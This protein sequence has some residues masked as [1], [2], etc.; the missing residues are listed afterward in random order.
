MKQVFPFFT[1]FLFFTPG[2]VAQDTIAPG[3]A[4]YV[5]TLEDVI[6]LSKEQS[7]QAIMARH[8]FRASY[9]SFRTYK[10][11]F[12]PK[13]VLTT[14]PASYTHSIQTISS[15]DS[16]GNYQTHETNVNTFTS[17]AGLSLSQN[18][19]LT[20]GS[21]ALGSNIRRVQNLNATASNTQY[22]TFPVTLSLS[23]P[24]N[25]YNTLKWDKKIEPVRFEQAKQTY[26]AQM[27]LISSRA[28]DYFFGLARQQVVLKMAETNYEN[29]KKLYEIS[30]GRYNI[31][32]IAEDALLKMELNCMT[33]ESDLYQAQIDLEDQQSRLRSFLG[34]RDN[35]EIELIISS[36]LPKFKIKFQQ[37]LDYALTRSP[38]IIRYNLELLT[39]ERN[40]AQAKSQKGVTLSVEGSYGLNKTADQFKN[41]Y[42]TPFID[43]EGISIGINIPILDW[44]Q[45]NDRYRNF[46]SL[47]EVAETQKAQ[48]EIDFQQNV[49]LQVARFNLQENQ[50]SIAAK[51]D[52]IA[53]KAYD[54]SMERYLI[55]KVS[56]TDLNI[57]SSDKDASKTRYISQLQNYW[58]YFYEVRRLTLFD[59]QNNRL[60]EVN[61]DNFI[62][63]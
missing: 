1:V 5:F 16:Q 19:G 36:E 15:T 17:R 41:A 53:Q 13:L 29:N 43:Q 61:F 42:S 57:A 22:T 20:G 46:Q 11:Q 45:A 38:E 4:K 18:I 27:E 56:V 39:A 58:N 49:Y 51:S 54:V 37:A 3:K 14:D 8:N 60:L 62:N 52:T 26:L 6:Q 32:T 24:L 59:F 35:V 50:V 48:N 9:Y 33:S 7:N 28:V 55:G 25:G 30:L 34:F 21:V 63:D 40:A 31:G 2:L 10:A 47:L 12:L 44:N 23:Q